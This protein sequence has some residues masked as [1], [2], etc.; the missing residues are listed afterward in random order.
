MPEEAKEFIRWLLSLLGP[1]ALAIVGWF[2]KQALAALAMLKRHDELL[3]QR[4]AS[5]GHYQAMYE[6]TEGG[7]KPMAM[8]ADVENGLETLCEKLSDLKGRVEEL[9]EHIDQTREDMHALDKSLAV[10][11]T[12]LS[13]VLKAIEQRKP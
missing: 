13:G 1:I 8:V 11:T 9:D 4:E 7:K 10:C 6:L 2:Y 3:R 5:L 12:S